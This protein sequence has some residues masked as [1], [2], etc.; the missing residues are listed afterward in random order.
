MNTDPEFKA[1][2]HDLYVRARAEQGLPPEPDPAIRAAVAA[3]LA[4]AP[5]DRQPS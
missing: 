1:W 4:T 2:V 3:I 5:D